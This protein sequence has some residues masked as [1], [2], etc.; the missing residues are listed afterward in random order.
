MDARALDVLHYARDEHVFAI[1]DRIHFKLGAH[2]VLI[3]EHGIFDAL[4]QDDR[5]VFGYVLRLEGDD[6]VLPAQHVG[7]PQQHRVAQRRRS[8]ERL[9]RGH[10]GAA[11]RTLDVKLRQKRIEALAVLRH[12]DAVRRGAQDAHA[13]R[14]EEI[15]E[16]DGSLPAEGNH[17]AVRLF[18]G[19]YAH[20]ILRRKR[21]E[22]QPVRRIKIRGNGFRVV[23]YDHDLVAALPQRPYAVHRGVIELDALADADGPRAE[24]QHGFA[25][26]ALPCKE[27]GRLV[28][29]RIRRV[30]IRRLRPEFRRA[31]VH[32]LIN[33]E[34][35]VCDL[36]PRNLLDHLIRISHAFGLPV[37]RIGERFR[38][39]A[40]LE[41][42]QVFKLVQKP[43]VD[44]GD[45]VDLRD[46]DACLERGKHGKETLIVAIV[47]L[48]CERI[49]GK[50]GHL[51][52][53][54]A[55]VA[56][57][58]AAHRLHERLFKRCADG[59]HF[60]RGLHLRAQRAL[61]I[62]EFIKRPLGQLYHHIVE[63]GLKA[64]AGFA[65]GNGVWDLGQGIADGDLC[66][67]FGD[68]VTRCL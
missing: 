10:H 1:A 64:G 3:N 67:D 62:H 68:G 56:D 31:G 42:N 40:C 41:G 37:Q 44:L 61:G 27:F 38:G 63:R 29:L 18:G 45:R 21:L 57:L 36:L 16:L 43:C 53:I 30:K 22:I 49:A 50:P 24:H 39:K 5:H 35:R 23:I 7:W 20:H 48:F 33:R 59:H 2:Q 6:H 13:L 28:F 58:R 32:H 15:R 17:H 55:G 52:R 26:A 66:R 12:V 51:G 47:E 11:A 54:E 34:Q 8:F 60:A 4:P 9:L 19:D 65:A 46:G 14:A 25:L